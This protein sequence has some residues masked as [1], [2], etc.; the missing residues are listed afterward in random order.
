MDSDSRRAPE[1]GCSQKGTLQAQNAENWCSQTGILLAHI[2]NTAYDGLAS[3]TF[4]PSLEYFTG[5]VVLF[6]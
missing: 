6:W 4:D 5:K 3:S 2:P 1:A